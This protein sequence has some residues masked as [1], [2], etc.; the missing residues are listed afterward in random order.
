MITTPARQDGSGD[1]VDVD[2]DAVIEVR[3]EGLGT[4]FD[5]SDGV[6]E[7]LWEQGR[8]SLDGDAIV[9]I[10]DGGVFEGQQQLFIGTRGLLA[11]EVA[12]LDD[13]QRV[14]VDVQHP[15]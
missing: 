15:S 11:F 10:V 4:P 8:V 3:L 6:A 9:E 12:R 5:P 14:C 13:P 7:Q 1:P 2:G